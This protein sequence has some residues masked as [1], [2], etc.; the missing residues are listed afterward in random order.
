M[1]S[2]SFYRS[3]DNNCAATD[4]TNGL[5]RS[6]DSKISDHEPLHMK[7]ELAHPT[8]RQNSAVGLPDHYK[9][10]LAPTKGSAGSIK[11]YVLPGKKTGVVRVLH[12]CSILSAMTY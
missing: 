7:A 4:Q 9:P 11:S 1:T 2:Q 10:T 3:W 12:F 8:I 5:D 6:S